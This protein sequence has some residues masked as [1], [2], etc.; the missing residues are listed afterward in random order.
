MLSEKQTVYNTSCSSKYT[1]WVMPLAYAIWRI[2]TNDISVLEKTKV[3]LFA[4]DTLFLTVNKITW[5]HQMKYFGIT[6]G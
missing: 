5:S 1:I 6:I 4:D 2:D 3:F